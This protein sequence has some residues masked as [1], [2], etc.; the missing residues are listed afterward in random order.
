M[1]SAVAGGKE[2]ITNSTCNFQ[3][4]CLQFSDMVSPAV[5][6]LEWLCVCVCSAS[7]VVL[8]PCAPS[9]TVLSL[10]S[11]AALSPRVLSLQ[12]LLYSL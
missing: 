4:D 3:F 9:Y 7:H 8:S 12:S 2:C 10:C 6:S 11:P 1:L 5:G